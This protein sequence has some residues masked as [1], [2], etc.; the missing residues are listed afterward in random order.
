ME[1]FDRSRTQVLDWSTRKNADEYRSELL[2]WPAWGWRVLAPRPRRRDFDIAQKAVLGLVVAGL[3]REA[4]ARKLHLDADLVAHLLTEFLGQGLLDPSGK[5]TESGRQAFERDQGDPADE[6]VMGWVFADPWDGRLWPLF[7]DEQLPFAATDVDAEGWQALRGTPGE[8]R[9]R[10]THT[11][12]PDRQAPPPVQPAALEVLDAIRRQRAQQDHAEPALDAP[13][14]HK[15][16]YI[17]DMPEP[18]FVVVRCWCNDDGDWFVNN[19]ATGRIDRALQQRIDQLRDDDERLRRHLQPIVAGGGDPE[20]IQ[21][22]EA[23]AIAYV[24]D[25]LRSMDC[26]VAPELQALLVRMQRCLAECQLNL[27]DDRIDNAVVNLQR[28]F[29]GICT[30]GI[31]GP[32]AEAERKAFQLQ[33][34]R[35]MDQEFNRAHLEQLAADMG[36]STGD[37]R[38][39]FKTQAGKIWHTLGERSGSLRPLLCANL[40]LARRD[41]KHPLRTLAKSHPDLLADLTALSHLRDHAAHHGVATD[42]RSNRWRSRTKAVTAGSAIAFEL[43]RAFC[44]PI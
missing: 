17:T 22:L 41:D 28:A 6:T 8:G 38:S 30:R 16:S 11:V 4:I 12:L 18:F 34:G 37:C 3:H 19:P 2:L 15:V 36:Y 32:Y 5:L 24:E 26:Q 39:L 21:N 42:A 13:R 27:P 29:E 9:G 25:Q 35:G 1:S 23:Q 14:V 20:R 33:Q 10:R 40:L 7:V 43:V 44:A 31:H